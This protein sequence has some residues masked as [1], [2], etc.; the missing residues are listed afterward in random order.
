[1]DCAEIVRGN[2]VAKN[3]PTVIV[4]NDGAHVT[5]EAAIGSVNQK[6]LET[7]MARGLDEDTAVDVI[8]R[9]MLGQL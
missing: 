5:H 8:I 2:A 7:L 4:R 9:G 1:M 3:V 6:E